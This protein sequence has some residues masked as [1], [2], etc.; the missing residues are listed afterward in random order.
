MHSVSDYLCLCLTLSVSWD[1]FWK[2]I[3][4]ETL[5]YYWKLNKIGIHGGGVKMS[6]VN[7]STFVHD[8]QKII[9]ICFVCNLK[10]NFLLLYLLSFPFLHCLDRFIPGPF[11][12]AE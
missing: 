7:V 6:K 9:V 10:F 5:I 3:K 11:I 12:S 2:L 8:I 1:N 4:C